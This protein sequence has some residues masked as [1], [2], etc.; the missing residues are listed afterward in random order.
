MVQEYLNKLPEEFTELFFPAAS[1]REVWEGLRPELR[2]DI[3]H[4]GENF[5]GY[6]WPALTCGDYLTFS[7]TGD[8]AAFEEKYYARRQAV[9]ALALAECAEHQG[10][11]LDELANGLWLICE[12][13]GWQLPAHNNYIRDTPPLPLPN[14]ERPVA[15]LFACETA[16]TLSLIRSLLGAEL[17]KMAPGLSRRILAETDRRVVR[18]YLNTH[19]WWMGNG[20]EPMCNWTAWCTQNVLLTVFTSG[21][22]QDVKRAVIKQAAYSLDCFLKDYGEDGCCEEGAVYYR[23][24]G[25]CLWGA[26]EVLDR[27]SGGVFSPIFR[28]EKIKN[29]ASYIVNV[30]AGGGWYLNYADCAPKAGPCGAPEY[31]FGHR[32]G[33]AALQALACSGMT[34][35][36][37]RGF[38]WNISLFVQLLDALYDREMSVFRRDV[39]APAGTFYPSTGLWVAR[40]DTW[41]VS[42]RAG[43]NGCSHGHC[44]SGSLIVYRR[45]RP[46]LIDIG[47]E[48]YTAKTFSVDRYSI[49]TMRSDWHNLPTVNGAVQSPGRVSVPAGVEHWDDG[50]RACISMELAPAYPPQAGDFSYRRRVELVRG[51]SLTVE[52]CYQGR[53]EAVLSLLFCEAP[54][55]R[56]SALCAA[57]GGIRL[58]TSE[59]PK[60]ETIPVLDSQLRKNWPDGLYRVLIP[61]RGRLTMTFY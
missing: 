57:E 14:T 46:L 6:D 61:V 27:V 43:H 47:V 42:V 33:D 45:G 48:S 34:D 29:I 8:R 56:D 20:D 32:T 31:L 28:E 52:D 35:E 36:T 26:L 22:S 54:V 5:L 38:M 19:F 23:R 50:A 17:E 44:D 15:D 60:I 18:P 4:R 11:F 30:H 40:D 51:T 59:A 39:P 1:D 3:I 12:E 41:C 7:R 49:W 55:W 13:S 37:P 24:A 16:E 53:G 21:Y 58:S 25:L 10:R 2:R 9:C